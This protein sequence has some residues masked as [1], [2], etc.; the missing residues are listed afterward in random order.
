MSYLAFYSFN[1]VY[2]ENANNAPSKL[3][4]ISWGFLAVAHVIQKKANLRL[5]EKNPSDVFLVFIISNFKPLWMNLF[6]FQ[7]F[8]TATCRT[9]TTPLYGSKSTTATTVNTEVTFSCTTGYTLIG[10]TVLTCL[11]TRQ[12]DATEPT[13]NGESSATVW[14]NGGGGGGLKGF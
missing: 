3:T 6:I 13:C 11:T 4:V 10:N 5:L 12:W 14:G 7:Q 1:T 8:A 9:L 2:A